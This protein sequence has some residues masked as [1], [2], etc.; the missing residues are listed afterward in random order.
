MF[1][2][3]QRFREEICGLMSRGNVIDLNL[4]IVDVMSHGVIADID[5]FGPAPNW[6]AWLF[7][8]WLHV[9]RF[10]PEELILRMVWTT[11]LPCQTMTIGPELIASSYSY[12]TIAD[13]Q[14]RSPLWITTMYSGLTWQ[15]KVC[16][17][18][19]CLH[20]QSVYSRVI[21][22]LLQDTWGSPELLQCDKF[23]SVVSLYRLQ[24]IPPLLK[25]T[26]NC[27]N[28]RPPNTIRFDCYKCLLR[29]HMILWT[30]LLYRPSTGQRGQ[31]RTTLQP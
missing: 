15:R 26:D 21:T 10:N 13:L 9:R 16:S 23:E 29:L 31:F 28:Q 4:A 3:F 18:D 2:R 14:L 20:C 19:R 27:S 17:S 24:T 5:V 11:L 22:G 1:R 6:E 8:S 7:R 25:P 12:S 30:C